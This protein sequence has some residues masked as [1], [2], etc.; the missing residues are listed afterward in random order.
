MGD[1]LFEQ[2]ERDYSVFIFP[3][4]NGHKAY[5]GETKQEYRLY[6]MD[7]I[8]NAPHFVMKLQKS[9]LD[10][11]ETN[12]FPIFE[13]SLV[14]D[15]CG[16]EM[17]LIW[18]RD[19]SNLI[20]QK[21]RRGEFTSALKLAVQFHGTLSH[22]SNLGEIPFFSGNLLNL[23]STLYWSCRLGRL[24]ELLI[25]NAMPLN[26]LVN[27][28]Q[29][30]LREYVMFADERLVQET[31]M[32]TLHSFTANLIAWMENKG[33]YDQAEKIIF[34]F[35]N[36]MENRLN[37]VSN[38]PDPSIALAVTLSKYLKQRKKWDEFKYP[39]L[40]EV[41]KQIP[42]RF[43]TLIYKPSYHKKE[44]HGFYQFVSLTTNRRR[45]VFSMVATVAFI[46]SLPIILKF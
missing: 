5:L 22:Y 43:F 11:I 18:A 15:D 13:G 45:M 30:V 35:V 34:H 39:R 27:E 20:V 19:F 36:G 6:S 32:E 1:D 44:L 33:E 10:L 24:K 7:Q 12:G 17:S 42:Y 8:T 2:Q 31:Q 3:W 38:P 28:Y 23:S 40:S 9:V 26:K 25:G 29:S 14:I 41:K 16:K 4:E 37:E 46:V 21:A